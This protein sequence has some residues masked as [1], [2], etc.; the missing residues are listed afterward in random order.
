MISK[1]RLINLVEKFIWSEN[2]N[3]LHYLLLPF[4]YLYQFIVILRRKLYKQKL[5]TS[6]KV[7]IPV[8]VVG[9]LT[10]GGNGKTPLVEWLANFLAK[11]GYRPCILIRGYKGKNKKFPIIVSKDTHVHAVGDEA[12]ML[13]DSTNCLTIVDP[14]R[15][16]AAKYVLENLDCNIII[17]DD[18]LQHYALDRDLEIIVKS[19]LRGFGNQKCIPAGPMREPINRVSGKEIIV[20]NNTNNQVNTGIWMQVK[21]KKICN[22]LNSNETLAISKLRN[23]RIL[24]VTSIANPSRIYNIF[25]KYTANIQHIVYPDHY[26]LEATSFLDSKEYDYVIMTKKDAVK[27]TEFWQDNF[28]VID[29]KVDICPEL[30]KI[31]TERLMQIA[32]KST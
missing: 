20:I 8:I 32:K 18:G 13:F 2:N 5:I 15:A 24:L 19:S 25:S 10:V 31:V 6:V 17:S 23:C 21:P 7:P 16:R 3:L 22:L 14:N 30:S 28:W 27:C 29:Y 12:K 1:I 11:K 9:N 4:S 26:M